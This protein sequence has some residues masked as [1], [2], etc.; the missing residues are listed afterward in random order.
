MVLFGQEDDS[1]LE[2]TD[3]RGNGHGNG[4]GNGYGNGH[5]NHD[6]SED[7]NP[8]TSI[9]DYIYVLG[10]V[11]AIYSGNRIILKNK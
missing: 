3:K 5:G 1:N 6:D 10:L 7:D 11:G 4:H 2:N 8:Q 9:S